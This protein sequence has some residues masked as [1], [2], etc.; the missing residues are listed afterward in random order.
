MC[1]RLVDRTSMIVT[2]PAM[3]I[4]QLKCLVSGVATALLISS[5]I[6][7]ESASTNAKT[8]A[9]SAKAGAEVQIAGELIVNLDARDASAGTATWTNKGSMGNFKGL[10]QPKLVKVAD[11]PAVQFNGKTDAY[12]SE[13]PAP[14]SITSAHARSIEV[15]AFNPSLDSSEECMVAWGRRGEALH[16]LS[17]NYGSEADYSA[18]THYDQDMGW[19]ETPAAGKWHHLVYTY[20]GKTAK[21]FADTAELGSGEFTLATTTGDHLNIAVENSAEGEPAFESEWD[22]GWPMSL[23][24]SIAAVRV[25]SGALTADQIKANFN[26]DKERFGAATK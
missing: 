11:Q 18:V 20:D 26:A 10:G 9:A 23:S 7:A 21:I 25:H 15:W 19:S 4:S 5:A 22:P 2:V 16:N 8:A 12:R 17:F 6:A 1:R 13:N 24:G 14:G 3:K